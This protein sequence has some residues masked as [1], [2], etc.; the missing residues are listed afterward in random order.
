MGQFRIEATDKAEKDLGK[1]F[2]SGNIATIKKIEK[3]FKEL[4]EHPYTGTG[5][6]EQ[7]R[8]NLSGYWSRR[9]N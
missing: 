4:S 6:P 2:K 9:I 3:L 5:Q 7:L 8:N 1:H